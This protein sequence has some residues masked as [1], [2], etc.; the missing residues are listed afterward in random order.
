MQA[1]YLNRSTTCWAHPSVTR[2]TK[3]ARIGKSEGSI[4]TRRPVRFLQRQ[5]EYRFFPVC[6]V[7]VISDWD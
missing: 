1:D 7:P 5:A 3:G 4:S 6:C 2:L